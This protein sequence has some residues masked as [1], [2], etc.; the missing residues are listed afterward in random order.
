MLWLRESKMLLGAKLAYAA[1]YNFM[2]L[3][4]YFPYPLSS[5]APCPCFLS[6]TKTITSVSY[7]SVDTNHF[8]C[9]ISFNFILDMS[10]NIS[11]QLKCFSIK[12]EEF[13]HPRSYWLDDKHLAQGRTLGN[14]VKWANLSSA[15]S[16][17]GSAF[18]LLKQPNLFPYEEFSVSLWS[19]WV[20]SLEGGPPRGS[21][22][23]AEFLSLLL[24]KMYLPNIFSPWSL[25][26][27]WLI[28]VNSLV[29]SASWIR[30]CR[31][32]VLNEDTDSHG[33][34]ADRVADII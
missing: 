27:L 19:P 6:Q 7:F 32:N 25:L 21:L 8:M 20:L 34:I 31:D 2:Y 22:L 11:K 9:N 13:N 24:I 3:Y 29:V 23:L 17:P 1:R 12:D 10:M 30:N 4:S 16:P 15:F 14:I 28:A 33:T 18:L 5:K 26:G